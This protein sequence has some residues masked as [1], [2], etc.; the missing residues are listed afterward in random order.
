MPRIE[1]RVRDASRA[2]GIMTISALARKAQLNP[3]TVARL[4]HQEMPPWVKFSTITKICH[5]LGDVSIDVVIVYIEQDAE[6]LLARA[7]R[8]L[9]NSDWRT[10][11]LTGY[12]EVS[13]ERAAQL[14]QAWHSAGVIAPAEE[15]TWWRFVTKDE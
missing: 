6:T 15:P 9:A 3:K 11:D 2:R 8:D 5:A 12:L 7:Q 10:N 1:S 14:V 4:W 13:H